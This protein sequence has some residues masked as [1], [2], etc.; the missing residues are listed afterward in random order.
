VQVSHQLALRAAELVDGDEVVRL[1]RALVR[2]PSH[3]PG[4]GEGEVVAYLRGYLEERGFRVALQEVSPGRLN[5]IADLGEGPEGLILEGHTDVV[6]P[7]DPAAWSRPPFSAERVDGR[8]YGRGTADM[9]GGLAA[10]IVAAQAVSEALG[11]PKRTLRL[12]ILVDEEGMMTGAKAFVAAGHARGFAGAIICEPEENEVC[13]WQRGALRVRVTFRGKMA[14]GAMPY[15][16]INPIPAAARF[17]VAAGEVQTRLQSA[18]AHPHLGLP[19][20]TPTVAQASAGDG[21]MNVI[22]ERA[23]VALD[24]RTIPGLPHDRVREALEAAL[25]EALRAAPGVEA[26]LEIVDDRP[27]T[28]TPRDAEVVSACTRALALLGEPVRFGGVP[29][30]TD[31]TILWDRA[32]VPIVTIGPGERTIPHQANEY[33]EERALVASARIYAAA[34]VLMLE[35]P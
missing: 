25:R 15:A 16:G 27:A 7:G 3:V 30:A 31:G 22:P 14:H 1:T 6:T 4:P 13:L 32:G 24:V 35:R 33:V 8:I 10:A 12:A 17:V 23:V 34:S 20:V 26:D 9:K 28:E 19:Y 2:L 11:T 29:G 5:L 21:Q 18:G